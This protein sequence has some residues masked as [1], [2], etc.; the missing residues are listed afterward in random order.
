MMDCNT[1]PFIE[2]NPS[3]FCQ[4]D[5]WLIFLNMLLINTHTVNGIE[6]KIL[7]QKS[8]VMKIL[9]LIKSILSH[10]G[11]IEWQT[12]NHLHH[13]LHHPSFIISLWI[14][15]KFSPLLFWTLSLFSTKGHNYLYWTESQSHHH[16]TRPCV[17][18]VLDP[19]SPVML[20]LFYP[21][22]ATLVPCTFQAHSDFSFHMFPLSA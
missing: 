6:Y 3:G 2:T 11:L 9:I 19:V 1:F 20:D 15:V 8:F 21:A 12:Y 7:L 10:V 4:Q 22:I 14:M 16:C 17:V 5:S 13:S 18:W